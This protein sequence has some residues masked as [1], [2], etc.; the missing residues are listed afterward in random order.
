M[1]CQTLR[2]KTIRLAASMCKGSPERRTILAMLDKMSGNQKLGPE[3]QQLKIWLDRID[4]ALDDH[5]QNWYTPIYQGW[6]YVLDNDVIKAIPEW[7]R[8]A[9]QVES[10]LR[11]IRNTMHDYSRAYQKGVVYDSRGNEVS[12]HDSVREVWDK[13]RRTLKKA[14]GNFID[15]IPAPV[16]RG[17]ELDE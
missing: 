17:P 12:Y 15:M 10:L 1:P 4:A 9:Q 11:P 8:P 16:G 14:I 13:N 3:A 2:S 6:R 7:K 5:S